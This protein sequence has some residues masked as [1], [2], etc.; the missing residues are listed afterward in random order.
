MLAILIVFDGAAA[1]PQVPSASSAAPRWSPLSGFLDDRGWLHHQIKLFCRHAPR[2]RDSSYQRHSR[3]GLQSCRSRQHRLLAGRRPSPSSG[4]SESPPPSAFSITWTVSAPVSLPWPPSS[5]PCFA[6][7]NGQTLVAHASPRPSSAPP[8]A[9]CPLEFQNRRKFSWAMA[10]RQ[11]FLGFL[12]ATL[13]LKLRLDHA[14][15]L[16]TLGSLRYSSL[17]PRF[18]TPLLSPSSPAASPAACLP[19]ATPGKDH[20]AHRLANLG[21]GQRGAVLTIYLGGR[22]QRRPLAP[23]GDVSFLMLAAGLVGIAVLLAMLLA[24]AWLEA[25]LPTKKTIA[26]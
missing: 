8:P 5:S 20:S 4:S 11:C 3:P 16:A 25:R 13:A 10:G 15:S 21:L 17:A 9:S 26:Q 7:L 2:R 12:M 1:P 6:Y 19:F 24:I 14:S 23:P 18:L 22:D